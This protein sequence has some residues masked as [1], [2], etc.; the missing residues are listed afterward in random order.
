MLNGLIARYIG[1]KDIP[2]SP[3]LG[4]WSVV[5]PAVQQRR[6]HER[7]GVIPSCLPRLW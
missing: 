3:G 7:S 1:N 6:G 4:S 2:T 5:K